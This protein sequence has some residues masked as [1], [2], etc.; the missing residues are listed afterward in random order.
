[1]LNVKTQASRAVIQPGFLSCQ[2]GDSPLSSLLP[3]W[4][5]GGRKTRL[6]CSPRGL[7]LS[8]VCLSDSRLRM[9]GINEDIHWFLVILV[10]VA[11]VMLYSTDDFP[12]SSRKRLL[13]VRYCLAELKQQGLTLLRSHGEVCYRSLHVIC[14]LHIPPKSDGCRSRPSIPSS[15]LTYFK[16]HHHQHSFC[17]QKEED[18]YSPMQK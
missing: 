1:M 14:P 12:R 15:P 16:L 8:L 11:L 17:L 5:P 13:F 2:V 6:G 4:K 9:P 18:W 3:C 10:T 7:G